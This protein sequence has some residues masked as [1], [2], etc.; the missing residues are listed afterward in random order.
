MHPTYDVATY[1]GLSNVPPHT[2]NQF[3]FESSL[4][5]NEQGP[6]SSFLNPS[7]ESQIASFASQLFEDGSEVQY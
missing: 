2:T 1:G 7:E 6:I 4:W 5:E 3:A